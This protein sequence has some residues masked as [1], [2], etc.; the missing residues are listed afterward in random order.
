VN[1]HDQ[2]ALTV[3]FLSSGGTA[4]EPDELVRLANALLATNRADEIAREEVALAFCY[5]KVHPR[6]IVSTPI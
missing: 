5:R 2:K 1:K 4:R 3:G 6:H